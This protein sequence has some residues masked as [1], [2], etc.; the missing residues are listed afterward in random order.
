M[1]KAA[2]GRGVID[3]DNVIKGDQEWTS[4]KAIYMV[5]RLTPSA[6]HLTALTGFIELCCLPPWVMKTTETFTT[7][8]AENA[9]DITYDTSIHGTSRP[10]HS[11]YPAVLLGFNG[12]WMSSCLTPGIKSQQYPHGG[13]N[14]DHIGNDINRATLVGD[15]MTTWIS[16]IR[17]EYTTLEACILPMDWTILADHKVTFGLITQTYYLSS[18][19]QVEIL[20]SVNTANTIRAASS[21]PSVAARSPSTP[22]ARLTNRTFS[23]LRPSSFGTSLLQTP[24]RSTSD[25]ERASALTMFSIRGWMYT[26]YHLLGSIGMLLKAWVVSSITSATDSRGVTIRGINNGVIK[27]VLN[28][29]LPPTRRCLRQPL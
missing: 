18:V 23:V 11:L 15:N 22:P 7:S 25:L 3:P 13:E 14:W 12:N 1:K 8:E 16:T 27:L 6:R 19:P 20:P 21:T 5:T 9:N 10:F 17:K 28:A 26:D 4:L 24:S 29:H 2:F